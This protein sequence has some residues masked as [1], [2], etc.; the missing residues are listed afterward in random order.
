MSYKLDHYRGVRQS[1]ASSGP[2]REGEVFYGNRTL[3]PQNRRDLLVT[4]AFFILIPVPESLPRFGGVFV[5]SG[6]PGASSGLHSC[7]PLKVMR[8]AGERATAAR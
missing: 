1:G 4:E 8:A 7:C 2:R 5:F 3:S 6:Q